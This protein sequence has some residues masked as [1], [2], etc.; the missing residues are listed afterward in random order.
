ML[1]SKWDAM[2]EGALPAALR[3]LERRRPGW[4]LLCAR[5]GCRGF[6]CTASWLRRDGIELQGRWLCSSACLIASLTTVLSNAP[7]GRAF[8]IPPRLP[9]RL[10]L[11]QLGFLSELNLQRA[12]GDAASA[13]A[14]LASV[15][16]ASG[17]ISEDQLA[18]ARAMESACAQYRLPAQ[19]VAPEYRLPLAIEQ[20]FEAVTVHG[21]EDRWLIGFVER[22]DRKLLTLAES[23]TGMR[24]EGCVITATR[25]AAQVEL[26]GCAAAEVAAETATLA[27]EHLAQ[28]AMQSG[29][30]SLRVGL[31]G[32]LV[33]ACFSGSRV[34]LDSRVLRVG[35][36]ASAGDERQPARRVVPAREYRHVADEKETNAP[37]TKLASCR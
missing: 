30:E 14:S 16:L 8:A 24:P 23:V 13:D 27:V 6:R 10:A 21:S 20:R 12:L 5:G 2:V 26:D 33:W 15:L 1:F 11:L 29:A 31:E 37:R 36:H 22:V 9:Y 7:R 19:A 34:G 32:D 18:M 28:C 35:V 3:M 4:V 25:R 17:E